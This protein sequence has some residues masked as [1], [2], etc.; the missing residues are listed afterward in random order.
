MAVGDEPAATEAD[1]AS[2]RVE[3]PNVVLTGFMGT[4]KTTVGRL[5]AHRLQY[6]FVDTDVLIEARGETIAEIFRSRGEDAFR[7]I[8]HALAADL[9]ARRGLV[10]STGGRMMLDLRNDASLG[11]SGRVFCLV[12]SPDAILARVHRDDP[13]RERP[14]LSV[15][16]P[17][18]RIVELLA[19]RAAGYARFE[20]V[21]TDGRE[22]GAVV[23]DIEARLN[24]SVDAPRARPG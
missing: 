15:A 3:R 10:V 24:A 11:R 17:R 7:E 13:R 4:G 20:Q 14:L 19:E 6:E 22:P 1:R 9:A 18:A 5:L 16:D 23:D 21:E 8:E 2:T 12:A